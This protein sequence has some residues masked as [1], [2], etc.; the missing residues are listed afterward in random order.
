MFDFKLNTVGKIIKG[1]NPEWFIKIK[2]D[3][4]ESGGFYIFQFK[5][6]IGDNDMGEAY[7][8]W[9]EKFEDIETYFDD[10]N[11]EVEWEEE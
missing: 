1:D 9:V 10:G 6:R 7:D 4:E 3:K 2:D 8:D 5:N 11:W